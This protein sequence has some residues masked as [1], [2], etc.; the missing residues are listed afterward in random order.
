MGPPRAPRR[1][2]RGRSL[3]VRRRDVRGG[4]A[5]RGFGLVPARP[6]RRRRSALARLRHRRG[7]VGVADLRFGMVS[8]EWRHPGHRRRPSRRR[9]RARAGVR[10]RP[11]RHPARGS[12]PA[13]TR[14]RSST[15]PRASVAASRGRTR[16]N[17]IHRND[18][19]ATNAERRRLSSGSSSFSSSSAMGLG[20]VWRPRR[21]ARNARVVRRLRRAR[22]AASSGITGGGAQRRAASNQ[23]ARGVSCRCRL[24]RCSRRSDACVRLWCPGTRREAAWWRVH[25]R[26]ARVRG[27]KRPRRRA[28]TARRCP[29]CRGRRDPREDRTRNKD[30]D[31]APPTTAWR[32]RWRRR[33]CDTIVTETPSWP[34]R[35]R[36]SG[37][38]GCSSRGGETR[39]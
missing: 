25:W 22:A 33:R 10:I 20:V 34:W 23:T 8:A 39:R 12:P 26:P 16:R 30:T 17:N 38:R 19:R 9:A 1:V 4:G 24:A 13:R 31:E 37:R 6:R 21:R 28:R 7:R 11:R 36:G 35:R 14:S 32:S 27:T 29:S 18:A 5:L 3:E 15:S 2:P